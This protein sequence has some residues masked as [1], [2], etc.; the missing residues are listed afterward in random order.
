MYQKSIL[1]R[2]LKTLIRKN[3]LQIVNN[4][5]KSADSQYTIFSRQRV[6][7]FLAF[8]FRKISPP[9]EEESKQSKKAA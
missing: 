2:E 4:E 6:K 5:E 8:A 1:K 3:A 7:K 9:A